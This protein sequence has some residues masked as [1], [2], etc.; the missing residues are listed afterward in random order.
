M[1]G[2]LAV[3]ISGYLAFPRTVSSNALNNFA[4]SDILMQVPPH[5]SPG[6][7]YTFA[8]LKHRYGH[9]TCPLRQKTLER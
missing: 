8:P 3:G 2:Y 6:P 7:Y 4:D 5:P 1:L 9:S